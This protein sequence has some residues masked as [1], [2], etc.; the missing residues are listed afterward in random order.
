MVYINNVHPEFNKNLLTTN[1]LNGSGVLWN[2][3]NA[4]SATAV[5]DTNDALTYEGSKVLTITT[6][7]HSVDDTTFEPIN[8]SE[9]SFI[10]PVTGK[11]I[12][13]CRVYLK[14]FGLVFPELTGNL[15]LA[16]VL[17]PASFALLPFTIGNNVI[18]EF[19]FEYNKWNTLYQEVTLSEGEAY[20]LHGILDQGIGAPLD[21]IWF[22]FAGFKIELVKDRTFTMPSYYTSPVDD[23]KQL[24]VDTAVTIPIKEDYEVVN[25]TAGTFNETLL[26]SALKQNKKITFI[27]SGSGITTLL[28]FAG[29][30]IS[31]GASFIVAS[32]TGVTLQ[33][34]GTNWVIVDRFKQENFNRTQWSQ[35][36]ALTTVPNAS[37]LNIL[38][39]IPNASK[40]VNGT[41]GGL[42][43]LNIVANGIIVPFRGKPMTHEIR[44]V[45]HVATGTDQVYNMELRRVTDNSVITTTQITRNPDSS[46]ATANFTTYTNSALDP[47][48]VGGFYIAFNNASGT[49][50]DLITNLNLFI[51]TYFR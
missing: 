36:I 20:Y 4:I 49:S 42:S 19:S 34:S 41:D 18:P 25:I 39:L 38:T 35:N 16:K 6:D 5:E 3:V 1:F 22:S 10:A 44:V 27:N 46:V 26:N 2:A 29:D 28:P 33:A 47:F 37:F 43:E 12:F 31:G 11:Y 24:F 23:V 14:N 9:Y 32:E 13:S 17:T 48:A 7:G 21:S 8:P 51:I 45:Y 30:T 15:I 40:V 50:A